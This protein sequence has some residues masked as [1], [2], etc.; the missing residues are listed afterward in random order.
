LIWVLILVAPACLSRPGSVPGYP[1]RADS[2]S[3]D[4]FEPMESGPQ[5]PGIPLVG[6]VDEV[7]GKPTG[8]AFEGVLVL[9]DVLRS[10]EQ[11][12]PLLLAARYELD[13]AL[14]KERTARGGFDLRF[15][16]SSQ[17]DIQGYY[18]NDGWDVGLE[19][20]L[21]FGGID[22]LG[23]YR[24]GRGDFA[25]YDGKSRTDDD[26]E[27]RLGLRVPLLRGRTIDA[28]RLA[29]LRAQIARD[30]A[31]PK[32]RSVRLKTRL[33]AA[34][35]YW[36]WVGSGRKLEVARTVLGLADAR[37]GQ[38]EFA[39]E[40]GELA[41]ISLVENERAVVS[42][43]SKL[44]ESERSFQ[45]A[46]IVLSLYLRD[47]AGQP[48]VPTDTELPDD[49]P[50]VPA[51]EDVLLAEAVPRALDQRP[52]IELVQLALRDLE[53]QLD[54]ASNNTLPDLDLGVFASQDVG[55]PTG[56]VDDKGP[57]EFSAG[58]RLSV[59]LQRNSARGR[60]EALE[61]RLRRARRQLQFAEDN[62]RVDVQDARSAVKQSFDRLAQAERN[63]EL[64][65]QLA[66]AEEIK[67]LSGQSDLFLLNLQE[68]QVALAG[69]TYA[70][71]LEDAFRA[72]A[73]YRAALG[74]VGRE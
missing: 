9:D 43:T 56:M 37:R 61:A 32:I 71:V 44:L 52:E 70:G 21:A 33:K 30:Q 22:V 4:W 20:P 48:I 47:A 3:Q 59:P 13:L 27:V 54:L 35:A 46:G 50:D 69:E 31:G 5:L 74:D 62:V 64:A 19:Q 63:V 24:L 36:K 2:S 16:A 25:S 26:G 67:V 38:L 15:Q 28:R 65:S 17:A 14:A 72:L 6:E 8:A 23:G 34:D 58:I 49:F 57:F 10:V 53:L 7:G 55:N 29:V 1:N 66:R 39:V 60:A 18:E 11:H 12:F 45:E 51:I 41:P 68:Q 42:R 40:Q 73:A